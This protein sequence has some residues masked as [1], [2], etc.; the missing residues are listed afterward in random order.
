MHSFDASTAAQCVVGKWSNWGECTASSR[1]IPSDEM[2]AL[3]KTYQVPATDAW[4][5]GRDAMRY[6][7]RM[8]EARLAERTACIAAGECPDTMA[9]RPSSGA[10]QCIG[11]KH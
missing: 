6:A 3:T 8:K 9:D 1:C 10:A 11:G 5:I 2:E 7:M 4:D